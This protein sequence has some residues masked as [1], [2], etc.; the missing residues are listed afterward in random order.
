MA[1]TRRG[2]TI[3]EVV[4]ALIVI[5]AIVVGIR[6]ATHSS[7][8]AAAQLK[9]ADQLR[10]IG[11]AMVTWCN[12]CAGEFPLASRVDLGSTTV[13]DLDRA[14]N[15]TAN[16]FSI[17]IYNGNIA[18]ALL[19]SV[20]ETNASIRVDG[21]YAYNSPA[22]AVQPMNALWDP[23]FSADFT[24]GRTS[25]MSFTH[26]QPSGANGK[27]RINIWAD[28]FSNTEAILANRGPEVSSVAIN[29]NA[30]RSSSYSVSTRTP[31]SLASAIHGTR[32]QW[33]GN[34]TFN[35]GHGEFVSS[36]GPFTPA[37]GNAGLPAPTGMFYTSAAGNRWDTIFFD[38]PDDVNQL[39][40]YLGIFTTAGEKP[41]D[42]TGIWD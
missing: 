3:L 23:A 31:T 17:L 21:D 41:S 18:P 33:R 10:Q 29:G 13:P 22:T 14:K 6:L 8:R 28:T 30:D 1:C 11:T 5:I 19:I 25:N 16:I 27:G 39:N 26:L 35:D 9:D 2:I 7:R 24:N 38:E 42:F 4:C 32:A 12:G 15:T 40:I 20:G 34:V 37:A 36:L